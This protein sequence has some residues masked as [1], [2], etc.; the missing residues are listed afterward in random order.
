MSYL[1]NFAII[2]MFFIALPLSSISSIPNSKII[3]I[4]MKS[5][6]SILI[7]DKRQDSTKPNDTQVKS[8]K[9]WG[10]GVVIKKIDENLYYVLTTSH[11]LQET[12]L[13]TFTSSFPFL[14]FN[15]TTSI[16]GKYD[17]YVG[18][19]P[20]LKNSANYRFR[21]TA[22]I[23]M[24]FLDLS[25]LKLDMRDIVNQKKEKIDSNK[26]P[27]FQ[28]IKFEDQRFLKKLDKIYGAGYPVMP[29]NRGLIRDLFITSSEINSSLRN[30]NSTKDLGSYTMVYRLG[31]K[32]G[33]SGGP[34]INEDGRLVGINGLTEKG[35]HTQQASSLGWMGAWVAS[36]FLEEQIEKTLE[37][38]QN[39][40]EGK[41]DYGVNIHD[42]VLLALYDSTHNL[43]K[44]SKF[45]NYLPNIDSSFK[46]S[47]K[48]RWSDGTWFF[49]HLGN[50]TKE[51]RKLAE[52]VKNMSDSEYRKKFQ[53]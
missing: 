22:W 26:L 28:P 12:S 14:I 13:I 34:V 3:Q 33:M 47:I 43:N 17:V 44:K 45:S 23:D 21:V 39:Y 18:G 25:V 9:K 52:E 1:N 53:K 4:L 50:N 7:E 24:P 49:P 2:L 19:A 16:K 20:E 51:I 42:F 37:S 29:G 41:Y 38:E 11:L 8:V 27:K 32:G 6:V 5:T 35:I 40:Q 15:E 36:F 30:S 48:K 46:S 31:V 10:S